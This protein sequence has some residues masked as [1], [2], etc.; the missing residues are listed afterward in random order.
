M[1][2]ELVST[3]DLN[4]PDQT[5]GLLRLQTLWQGRCKKQMMNKC[6]FWGVIKGGGHWTL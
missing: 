3:N 4:S 6:D 2:K 5:K 1:Q